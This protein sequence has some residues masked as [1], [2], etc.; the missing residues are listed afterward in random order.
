MAST[1]PASFAAKRAKTAVTAPTTPGAFGQ[2]FTITF[3]DQA[4]N[5][6]GMQKIGKMADRGFTAEE[7][8]QAKGW[9]EGNGVTT[10]LIELHTLLPENGREHGVDPALVLV[11]RGGLSA[12]LDGDSAD[13]FFEEQRSLEKDSKAF[14][15]GRVVN[16]HARHNLC[17][18][19]TAQDPD[20]EHGRGR[21]VAF[22]SVPLLRK[23]CLISLGICC[24]PL[25]SSNAF[26]SEKACL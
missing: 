2:T 6:V 24:H 20:Y 3:G 15:Y 12:L 17:F 5:H 10:E 4:E 9:F 8:M 7:L 21:V 26:R 22:D 23:A 14:M 16:K 1:T 13:A 18:A 25:N 19:D 11:A